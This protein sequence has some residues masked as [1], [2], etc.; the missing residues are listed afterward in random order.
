LSSISNST[1]AVLSIALTLCLQT[2][3]FA[4]LSSHGASAVVNQHDRLTSVQLQVKVQNEQIL[5]GLE[6]YDASPLAARTPLVLIHGIASSA[7]NS[8][9]WENFLDYVEKKADFQAKYKI[10][11]Y[12]YDSTRSVPNISKNLQATLKGF[13]GALGGRNVKIL[14]YSEGG[15]LTRNALQDPYLDAHTDEVLAI[16]TPFHGSPL[17][18]PQWIQEQVKTD[19]AFSLMRMGQKI[20]YKITGHLYPTFRQDFHWDN[21]DGAI[22][23]AEYIKDNGPMENTT[24]TLAKKN[25]FVTYGSYF[26]MNVDPSIIQKELGL[27]SPQ[28]KEKPLL[29][30]LF[31]KNFMFSLV[32]NNIGK[33]PLA[34]RITKAVE[35]H[36]Q[37]AASN[38]APSAALETNLK[39]VIPQ[40][41]VLNT[42]Q[43]LLVTAAD[44]NKVIS[45][46]AAL[47]SPIEVLKAQ[48][49]GKIPK[50][51]PVE[52]VSMMMFNDGISPISSSLWLGRYTQ[53]A[54][55]SS[56]P[57]ERLWAALKALK[58]SRQARLFAGLDHRN[59]MDGNTRTGQ[60]LL[61]DLL[62]PDEPPRTVFD[63]IVYDLM[64]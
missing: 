15:L 8:F 56:I 34:N 49:T 12:H 11:L 53:C 33:L 18:N 7:S 47:N 40:A 48:A 44:T 22:P 10:Y 64:S 41:P 4:D 38:N 13:I 9:N 63:W 26:G 14:A 50:K 30:N 54:N 39:V 20:A 21:F 24:Y 37:S 51:V 46:L 36:I 57:V 62:N 35:N 59:W 55:G 61:Q 16:A 17:A 29:G 5:S 52:A 45:K 32:R 27:M 43:T 42:D 31:R 1:K 60:D 25:H 6:A 58:G 19:G 28:P 23:M 2:A 3:S